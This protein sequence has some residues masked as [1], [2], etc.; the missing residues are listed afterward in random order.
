MI[1]HANLQAMNNNRMLGLN[2]AKKAK[3]TEKLSSGY[4]INRSADDSSGLSISEKM[5]RQIRGLTQAVSNAQEGIS[6]CQIADGAL[7]EVNDM[8]SRSKE[9]VIQAANG[10]NTDEDRSYIQ[11]EL[12]ELSREVDRV[13]T[14]TVFNEM[15]IFSPYGIIPQNREAQFDSG[16]SLSNGQEIRIQFGLVDS[17][18]NVTSVQE[19]AATGIDNSAYEQNSAIAQYVVDAAANA[20]G[21]VA[22]SYPELFS[23]ASSSTIKIGLNLGH[24]D[25]EGNTLAYAQMAI[26][27]NSTSTIATY[28]MKIDTGDFSIENFEA[29]TQAEKANLAAVVA[30]E[31]THLV[32]YDTLTDGMLTG[33]TTS[34]P[35]WFTEGMAQTSS[36][37]NGWVSYSLNPSSG[38][39]TIKN[40]MG[41]L[42]SMP[43]GAG[44]LATMY[45]GYAVAKNG[46]S[47][48]NVDSA[49]IKGGLDT[50]MKDMVGGRKTLHQAIQDN[51]QYSG[52]SDFQQAFR[53]GN[54]EALNFVKDLLAA[55]G[56]TGVGSL[57]GS[58]GDS[59]V[60]LF[61]SFSSGNGNYLLQKDNTA[62]SNAFGV[63]YT[64]PEKGSMVGGESGFW[65]QV[66][67]EA[68][69]HIE[70]AQFN[71]S[72]E[73][74]FN[75]LSLNVMS[76]DAIGTSLDLIDIAGN[77]IAQVRSYYGAIQNR[78][79]HTTNNLGNVVENL[80]AAESRIRDT[81]MAKE[82]VAYSN[83]QILEQAGT[84]LLAQ[85][86]QSKQG[87]LTLLG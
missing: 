38:D 46:N 35:K 60:T 48:A 27:S 25:G 78:L 12:D 37:D 5:R 82:M 1:I 6:F 10:T 54:D 83:H 19:T 45:L 56:T 33:R 16:V 77:R 22:D 40:Y 65:L 20:V 55:R 39:A 4:R 42:D 21:K 75:N 28:T 62:Y 23:G 14:T 59:E 44:Y 13:H 15:S 81:D 11:A 58:L 7:H 51:T 47:S 63:G 66:G 26:G 29:S 53:S 3:S 71:I 72:S 43:Y 41:Q 49:T 86:N 30:H 24:I 85:T 74:L 52:L 36:G 76:E 17:L 34:F 68:G 2:Q 69:Q 50:L 73:A 87:I 80:T 32:M 61:G 79:E 70:V 31:M 64:F 18:G 67:A 8:L 57:L 84:A 9:L